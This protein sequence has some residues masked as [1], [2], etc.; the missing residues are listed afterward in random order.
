[1]FFR[2]ILLQSTGATSLIQTWHKG[3]GLS[4]EGHIVNVKLIYKP[5]L[6]DTHKKTIRF[7]V[8]QGCKTFLTF[9]II[10]GVWLL[11]ILPFPRF[12]RHSKTNSRMLHESCKQKLK[13]VMIKLSFH[14][15]VV[16]SHSLFARQAEFTYPVLA[17]VIQLRCFRFPVY[18]I[19]QH[20]E[21]VNTQR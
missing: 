12:Q 21:S 1:M 4:S 9:G 3:N 17:R 11:D 19:V 15:D 6:Q 13:F 18:I 8:A 2:G 10:V 20:D 5:Q 16:T 7:T 14:S